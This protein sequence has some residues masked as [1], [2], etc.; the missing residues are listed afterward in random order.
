M[1]RRSNL[2]HLAATETVEDVR[3]FDSQYCNNGS[4]EKAFVNWN[5]NDDW[6]KKVA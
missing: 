4:P 3:S 1:R 6:S 5:A 2:I